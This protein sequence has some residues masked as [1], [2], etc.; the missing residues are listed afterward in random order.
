MFHGKGQNDTEHTAKTVLRRF[1]FQND[2]SIENPPPGSGR[3][4]EYDGRGQ[5]VLAVEVSRTHHM[6]TVQHL[7]GHVPDVVVRREW[8]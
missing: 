3:G 8:L 7:V 2:K 1:T 5:D 6:D 4:I